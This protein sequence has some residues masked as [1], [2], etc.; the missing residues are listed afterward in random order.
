MQVNP[1]FCELA[2]KSQQNFKA[3]R[4]SF[5]E[6]IRF[7]RSDGCAIGIQRMRQLLNIYLLNNYPILREAM[8]EGNANENLGGYLLASLQ[9][10]CSLRVL[11]HHCDCADA[12]APF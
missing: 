4:M 1:S 3:L 2:Y 11:N 6:T 5:N 9:Y 7:H 12:A 8:C 10:P